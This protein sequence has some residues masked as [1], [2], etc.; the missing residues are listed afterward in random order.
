MEPDIVGQRI[1]RIRQLRE[2]TLRQL[3]QRSG[4]PASTLSLVESGARDGANLTLATGRKLAEALGV[5]LDWLSGVYRD[6]E[7]EGQGWPPGTT[8]AC[9][10]V[11]PE[12]LMHP[13][14]APASL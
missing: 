7:R 3:A 4:V 12:G 2:L 5:T 9:Q 10:L 8:D 1:K 13:E 6:E 14:M 11:I